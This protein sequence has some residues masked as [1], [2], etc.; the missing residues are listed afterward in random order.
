MWAQASCKVM[1]L[2]LRSA[3]DSVWGP[4]QMIVISSCMLQHSGPQRRHH[5]RGW[6][7]QTEKSSA[8]SGAEAEQQAAEAE[9]SLS[10]LLVEHSWASLAAQV[11]AELQDPGLA[12]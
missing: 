6:G 9:P 8:R 12:R 7:S 3:A 4:W 1:V 10:G 11:M 2:T 5:Y